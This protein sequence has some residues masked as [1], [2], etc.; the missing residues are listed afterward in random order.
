[1][2]TN[3]IMSK[4][5]KILLIASTYKFFLDRNVVDKC[6]KKYGGLDLLYLNAGINGHIYFKDI[7]D[8][9]IYEKLMK[10]NYFGY[11]YPTR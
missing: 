3:I 7:K 6:I 4:F 11:I 8:F 9:D 1:M 2:F 10:T 5:I